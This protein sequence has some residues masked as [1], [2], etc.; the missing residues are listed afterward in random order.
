LFFGQGNPSAAGVYV[1]SLD[2]SGIKRLVSSDT[3]GVYDTRGF[4]LF[5]RQGTLFSQSFD[6]GRMKAS[7]DSFPLADRFAGDPLIF[8]SAFGSANAAIVYR[9]GSGI[10][11]RQLVWFDRAGK[12]I[13][14]L[15]TPDPGGS[16]VPELSPDEKQVAVQRTIDGNTD[17]W[18]IDVTKGVRSRHTSDPALDIY[19]IWAPDGQWLAFGSTRRGIY[20]LYRK[21]SSN[22]GPEELLLASPQ[23][24]VPLDWSSDGKFILYRETDLKNGYDL[25]AMPMPMS[26]DKK[27]FPVANTSFDEFEGQF[28]PDVRWVT[29][30]SYLSGNFDIYVEPFGRVGRKQPISKNG[31]T[32]PRW[33]HDG[34]EIFYVAPDNTLMSV[35]IKVSTGQSLDA[36][37]PAPLFRSR[38]SIN[39]YAVTPKQQYAVSRDGQRFLMVISL[40]DAT[41][42]PI[43]VLL[44]WKPKP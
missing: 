31:G 34:T 24:K 10:G 20:D 9:S 23:N 18:I 39:S 16:L 37:T 41:P 42:S 33:R 11:L 22:A 4:L 35:P 17:V 13:A 15:G 25:W 3:T 7:G 38:L 8:S 2:E 28:S 12:E 26:G 44:N 14:T 6:L 40:E 43:T 21:L 36:G 27:P 5:G 32:Q 19:P 29:Y 30:T 1:G